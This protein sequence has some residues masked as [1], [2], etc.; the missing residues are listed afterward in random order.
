VPTRV[1]TNDSA[2]TTNNVTK[3]YTS[4]D[5]PLQRLDPPAHAVQ[6][7]RNRRPQEV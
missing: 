7:T 4:S 2:T 6:M 5:C 1:T 3:A